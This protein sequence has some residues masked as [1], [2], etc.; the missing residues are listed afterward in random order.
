MT[1]NDPDIKYYLGRLA[2]SMESMQEDIKVI[3]N[4]QIPDGRIRMKE[5][6]TKVQTLNVWKGT[7]M[8]IGGTVIAAAAWV[9]T[10]VSKL[11][12]FHG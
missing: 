8:A 1:I 2:G 4:A 10:Q 3:K 12:G 11:G 9:V 5:V 7:V 6:E